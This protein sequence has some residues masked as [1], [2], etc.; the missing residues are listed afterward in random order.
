MMTEITKQHDFALPCDRGFLQ[1]IRDGSGIEHARLV[2]VPHKFTDCNCKNKKCPP[3]PKTVPEEDP[4][5]I[6]CATVAMWIRYPHY[7]HYVDTELNIPTLPARLRKRGFVRTALQIDRLSDQPLNG[8]AIDGDHEWGRCGRLL[9]TGSDP[10]TTLALIERHV[11][12]VAPPMASAKKIAEAKAVNKFIKDF[13][14]S[15]GISTYTWPDGAKGDHPG[16]SY[17][18]LIPPGKESERALVNN[19][20]IYTIH[21]P[22]LREL[23]QQNAPELFEAV[24]Q[25]IGLHLKRRLP[26]RWQNKSSISRTWGINLHYLYKEFPVRVELYNWATGY[27]SNIGAVAENNRALVDAADHLADT[28]VGRYRVD[29]GN[30]WFDRLSDAEK[31]MRYVRVGRD[32]R[33]CPKDKVWIDVSGTLEEK[34]LE[35]YERHRARFLGKTHEEFKRH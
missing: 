32:E 18:M 5:D 2:Q 35:E 3:Y 7:P 8:Y 10:A 4:H 27:A 28:F 24:N 20:A 17:H 15:R 14:K 30:A 9:C 11:G 13:H 29:G 23:L 21:N 22:V 12:A 25:R 34:L 16:L 6:A 31:L 19:L 26:L 1:V 33:W